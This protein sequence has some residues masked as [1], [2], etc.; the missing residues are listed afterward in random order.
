MRFWESVSTVLNV[1]IIRLIAGSRISSGVWL[2]SI[3]DFSVQVIRRLHQS[4]QYRGTADGPEIKVPSTGQ[5]VPAVF[6]SG[7]AP[8][9]DAQRAT[10]EILADWVTSP[11]NPWFARMAA[12]RMWGQFFGQAIVHP[13]DDFSDANP[14]SHPEVLDLLAKQFVLHNFDL[15]YLVRTIT[16]TRVY[17]RTSLQTHESQK[18]PSMFARSAL[19]GLTPEQFFDS[20]AEAVGYYQPFR[21]DNPFLI[22]DESPRA[23][24]LELYRSEASHLCSGIRRFCRHW[25]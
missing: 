17:Q 7:E 1:T 11:E 14:P 9:W 24:F 6:L 22:N 2:R 25:P 18:D 5:T 12:N 21:T 4:C 19:R 15:N 20:L 3:P 8:N 16:A 10:R 23:R 13:M